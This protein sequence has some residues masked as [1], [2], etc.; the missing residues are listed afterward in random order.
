MDKIIGGYIEEYYTSSCT[1]SST[2]ATEFTLLM[3]AVMDKSIHLD[4][5]Y[6]LLRR[7]PNDALLQLQPLLE[8]RQTNNISVTTP[9]TP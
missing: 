5:L 9:A 3:S 4:G 8:E 7:D 1:T 2:S 6:I